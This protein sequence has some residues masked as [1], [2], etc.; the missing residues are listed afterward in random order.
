[1]RYRDSGMESANYSFV[2]FAIAQGYSVFFYDR[3]GTGGSSKYDMFCA[4][5]KCEANAAGI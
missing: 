2:D 4:L 5:Q 1:M 3:L